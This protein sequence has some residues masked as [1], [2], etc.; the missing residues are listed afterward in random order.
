MKTFV[1]AEEIVGNIV[2]HWWSIDTISFR[3]SLNALKSFQ[4]PWLSKVSGMLEKVTISSFVATAFKMALIV[5][6]FILRVIQE[7][8]L[9]DI[10]FPSFKGGLFF[11]YSSRGFLWFIPNVSLFISCADLIIRPSIRKNTSIF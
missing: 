7:K 8:R 6:T 9:L 10:I 4:I 5:V 2:F 3:S 1:Y 11:F